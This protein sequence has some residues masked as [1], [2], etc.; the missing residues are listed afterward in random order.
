M[1]STSSRIFLFIAILIGLFFIGF[2]IANIY[3]F[4]QIA[5]GRTVSKTTAWVML[6]FNV[7]IL[8]LAFILTVWALYQLFVPP[9]VKETITTY[10]TGVPHTQY[11]ATPAPVYVQQ[12]VAAPPSPSSGREIVQRTYVPDVQRTTEVREVGTPQVVVQPAPTA[13]AIQPLPPPPTATVV[14]QSTST[15]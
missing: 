8:I 3:Y 12:P 6:W 13:V 7:A 1:V 10:A 11:V 15:F 5:D 2:T 4:K 14:R 9:E